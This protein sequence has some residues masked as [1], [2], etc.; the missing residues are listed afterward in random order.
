[1]AGFGFDEAQ[2]MFRREVRDFARKEL[3]PGA[4]DRAKME[5]VPKEIMIRMGEVGLLG[6]N[7]PEELGG[8]GADWVS[9]GIAI[10]ELSKI[11]YSVSLFPILPSVANFALRQSEAGEELIRDW[12]PG[13]IRGERVIGFVRRRSALAPA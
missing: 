10:E 6:I 12:L 5:S 7:L 13:A 11:D 2:E 3:A 1:M 9:V 8:G 4:K